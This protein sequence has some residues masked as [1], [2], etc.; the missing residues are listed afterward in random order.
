MQVFIESS[1]YQTMKKEYEKEYFKLNGKY[2][3]YDRESI[4]ILSAK[5][6]DEFFKNKIVSIEYT[7]ESVS[8]KGVKSSMTKQTEK[9]FYEIWS[10]DPDMREY[11]DIT[12][13]CDLNKVKKNQFNM[14]DGF[15][16]FDDVEQKAVDLEPIF[17]HIRSLVDYNEEHFNYV[18]DYF[19]QLFQQPH[20]LP[21]KT[22]VFISQEGVGKD[23][24]ATFLGKVMGEK[25]TH[26]TEK[27]E[28][29]CGKFNSV[30]GGKMMIVINETNPLESRERCENIKFLIT[31]EKV[32]IEAKHKDPITVPN[33]S[34]FIFFSNRQM[35]FPVEGEGSRRPVIF[36]SS[37][38]YLKENIGDDKNREFFTNLVSMYKNIYYQKAFLDFLMERNIVEFN[39][40]KINKSDLH[41]SLEQVSTSP[42]VQFL[43]QFVR[44][45]EDDKIVRVRTMELHKD[46]C[47]YLSENNSNKHLINSN[48]FIIQMQ[49]TYNIKKM[50]SCGVAYF[51]C[52][53]KEIKQMLI[54]KYKCD[55]DDD[56]QDVLE[57]HN[58]ENLD[59]PVDYEKKCKSLQEEMIQ[60]KL[61]YNEDMKALKAQIR[62]AT[63]TESSPRSVLEYQH[64]DTDNIIIEN[65]PM[66]SDDEEIITPAKTKL[67]NNKK[68]TKKDIPSIPKLMRQSNMDSLFDFN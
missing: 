22:L 44:D 61:K 42:I 67:N 47:T 21:H 23:I 39:P 34:R 14:F 46:Y 50:K 13:E 24:F 29:I 31:T 18:L 33:F 38:K 28:S 36:Q 17:E 3:R 63:S 8:K 65:N 51:E 57:R 19:A 26:N 25:Y 7:E 56:E 58:F 15:K 62:E 35:S 9:T 54:T 37:S 60:M 1:E 43:E 40:N 45:H 12:F 53:I 2:G 10:K 41:K 4:T 30:I 52:N 20:I 64:K 59:G 11:T 48:P 49:N 66:L 68:K 16:H 6:I 27:L 55:F 5:E 32:S